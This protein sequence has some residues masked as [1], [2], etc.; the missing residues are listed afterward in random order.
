MLPPV[1]KVVD[2]GQLVAG[3]AEDL[4][5]A[6][7]GLTGAVVALLLFVERRDEVGLVVAVVSSGLEAMQVG[8]GP[9]HRRLKQ[10]VHRVKGQVTSQGQTPPDPGLRPS[11]LDAE[12]EQTRLVGRG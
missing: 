11:E 6:N 5:E 2:V 1:T 3:G 7:I 4:V 9:S 8:V 10:R 12:G